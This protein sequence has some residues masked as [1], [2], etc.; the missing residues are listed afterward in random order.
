[1]SRFFPLLPHK[2]PLFLNAA[3]FAR[4]RLMPIAV[5]AGNQSDSGQNRTDFA[6]F[7]R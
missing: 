3:E 6:D 2:N 1:M 5:S 4:K 7:P